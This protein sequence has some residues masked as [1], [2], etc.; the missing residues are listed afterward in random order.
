MTQ[1]ACLARRVEEIH[2]VSIVSPLL[3]Y[4]MAQ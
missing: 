4:T 3:I 1:N 2:D